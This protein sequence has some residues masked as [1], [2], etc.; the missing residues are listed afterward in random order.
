LL[1]S[2]ISSLYCYSVGITKNISITTGGVTITAGPL[3]L[4][5]SGSPNQWTA[6]D[7]FSVFNNSGHVSEQLIIDSIVAMARRL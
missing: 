7:Q 3:P 2:W 4:P 6:G 1:S 5:G